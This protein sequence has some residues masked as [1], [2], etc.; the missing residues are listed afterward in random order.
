MTLRD[1]DLRSGAN[2]GRL[3]LAPQKRW[4]VNDPEALAVVLDERTRIQ[5]QFNADGGQVSLADLIV[6]CRAVNIEQAALA[7][8]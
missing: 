5:E 3:S 6:L 1:N 7:A 4:D 2:R 8:G